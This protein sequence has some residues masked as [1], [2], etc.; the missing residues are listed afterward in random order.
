MGNWL[1]E[2]DGVFVHP[3]IDREIENEEVLARVNELIRN[4]MVEI[5][6]TSGRVED[7]QVG[8]QTPA[9][10][11]SCVNE[12]E[13]L[14]REISIL[15]ALI[16][17]QGTVYKHQIEMLQEK[18]AEARREKAVIADEI[19]RVLVERQDVQQSH[20]ERLVRLSEKEQM[21]QES[22]ERL[23]RAIQAKRECI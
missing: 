17:C 3:Y 20:S 8:V 1:M 6:K 16:N 7:C 9:P 12:Y 22:T 19:Q 13:D 14:G 11:K 23:R 4:E 18:L 5:P 10:E 15:E 21:L 2:F